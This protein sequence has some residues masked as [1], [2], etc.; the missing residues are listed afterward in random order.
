MVKYIPLQ[1]LVVSKGFTDH[2]KTGRVDWVL[3]RSMCRGWSWSHDT[4][5][6][7]SKHIMKKW[8]WVEKLG[9]EKWWMV[10][11]TPP[12]SLTTPNLDL[13]KPGQSDDDGLLQRGLHLR[14]HRRHDSGHQGAGEE[15]GEGG[16]WGGG[17]GEA[18]RGGERQEKWRWRGKWEWEKEV[19]G[20]AV[21]VFICICLMVCDSRLVAVLS[22]MRRV[23][24][25]VVRP[26]TLLK[27][28]MQALA[29]ADIKLGEGE[30]N[31]SNIDFYCDVKIVLFHICEIVPMLNPLA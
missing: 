5:Y 17:A 24:T 22:F 19:G 11:I 20:T 7:L 18:V 3:I 10:S 21:F 2:R 8:K 23:L 15:V 16:G 30:V 4:F 26:P 12:A 27:A 29:L 25:R 13:H 28:A 31:Q 9:K 14:H 6:H 1:C